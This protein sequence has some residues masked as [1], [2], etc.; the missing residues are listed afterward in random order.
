MDRRTVDIALLAGLIAVC[1]WLITSIHQSTLAA[2]QTMTAACQITE[3][4]PS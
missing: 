1:L 3:E 4:A 2:C